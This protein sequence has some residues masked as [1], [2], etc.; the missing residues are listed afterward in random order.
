MSDHQFRITVSAGPGAPAVKSGEAATELWQEL[1]GS[2]VGVERASDGP[3][4]QR[5]VATIA[6]IVTAATPVLVA[7]FASV[8]AWLARNDKG[9]ITIETGTGK[10]TISG[11]QSSAEQAKL[12]AAFREKFLETST[13]AAS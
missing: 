3:G 5:D 1:R 12:L 9:S 4:G 7:A 8:Q 10:I 2:S 11:N 6:A 13:P